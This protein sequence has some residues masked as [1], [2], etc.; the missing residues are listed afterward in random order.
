MSYFFIIFKMALT[1]VINIF[2]EIGQNTTTLVYIIILVK[3]S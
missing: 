1:N 3:I 2:L